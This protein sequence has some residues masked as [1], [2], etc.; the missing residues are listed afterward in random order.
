MGEFDH[1][2]QKDDWIMC[3]FAVKHSEESYIKDQIMAHKKSEGHY[4]YSKETSADSHKSTNGEHF[5]VL[6]QM[7]DE[8][9]HKMSTNIKRKYKLSGKAMNGEPRQYGKMSKIKCMMD[10]VS[11]TGKDGIWE[12]DLPPELLQEAHNRSYQKPQKND[13]PQTVNKRKQTK[14]WSERVV[15][16]LMAPNPKHKWNHHRDKEIIVDKILIC[17]GRTAKKMSRKIFYELYWGIYNALPKEYADHRK[18][19]ESMVEAVDDHI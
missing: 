13:K 14:T 1:I 12:S 7:D 19:V 6:V 15:D 11:Y 16:E 4:M 9:Y 10:A 3:M 5:H 2:L 17:L 8:S 18:V